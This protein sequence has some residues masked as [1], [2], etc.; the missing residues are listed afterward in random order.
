MCKYSL[1]QI[2]KD[3]RTHNLKQILNTG[4]ND[5]IDQHIDKK[6]VEELLFAKEV[7]QPEK[8]NIDLEKTLNDIKESELFDSIINLKN[9]K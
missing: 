9:K 2:R 8:P 6:A 7:T 3:I 5:M 1:S 4:E